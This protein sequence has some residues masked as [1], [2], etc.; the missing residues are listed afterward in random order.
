VCL[1]RRT[2]HRRHRESDG[3]R[4]FAFAR[5][6]A[7]HREPACCCG[8][9]RNRVLGSESVPSCNNNKDQNHL[10]IQAVAAARS[11]TLRTAHREGLREPV[12]PVESRNSQEASA[13]LHVECVL[14]SFEIWG[15]V[16]PRRSDSLVVVGSSQGQQGHSLQWL[17][18]HMAEGVRC[19]WWLF[20]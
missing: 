4:N 1:K 6:N 18:S 2:R 10:Q 9:V 8:D 16:W 13:G 7:G 19:T 15:M 17:E 5:G 3:E 11:C 12:G 20:K 14:L